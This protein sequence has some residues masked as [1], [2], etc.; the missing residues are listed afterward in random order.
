MKICKL[1]N[2]LKKI[3]ILIMCLITLIFAMPVKSNAG[4]IET[5]IDIVL[6]I[7]DW[8]MFGL[9][10]LLGDGET[11]SYIAVNYKGGDFNRGTNGHIYNF[12]I[13]P[14]E[15]FRAGMKEKVYVAGTQT[16]EV[17]ASDENRDENDNMVQSYYFAP[18]MDENNEQIKKDGKP[19]W[20]VFE[21]QGQSGGVALAARQAYND[22][23]YVYVCEANSDDYH[24][25]MD[26]CTQDEYKNCTIQRKDLRSMFPEQSKEYGVDDEKITY[27]TADNLIE[28]ERTIIP[29]LDANFFDRSTGE[30]NN[31][32]DILRPVISGIYNSLTGFAI[33]TMMVVLLYI[34]IRIIISSATTEQSKYKQL[35]I[36]WVI[37]LCL[38]FS[39]HFIMSFIMSINQLIVNTLGNTKVDNY[40]ISL[41]NLEGDDAIGLYTS[42]DKITKNRNPKVANFVA[43][44]LDY[45]DGFSKFQI[46]GNGMVNTKKFGQVHINARIYKVPGFINRSVL[47]KSEDEWADVVIYRCN[48]AEYLRSCITVDT[49]YVTYLKYKGNNVEAQYDGEAAY[50]DDQS[51]DD[52]NQDNENQDDDEKQYTATFWAYAAMYMLV[53]FQTIA[54]AVKYINRVIK[55][56]FL[57]MIAP[58]IAIMYPMD[59]VG[60][61]KAQ[62]FNMWFKEYLF[63]TLLQPLH[64][65]LYTI[66]IV[67]AEELAQNHCIYAIGFYAFMLFAEGFFKKMFGFD[68]ANVPKGLGSPMAYEFGRKIFDGITGLG[69]PGSLGNKGGGAD[70]ALGGKMKRAKA[71]FGNPMAN[72]SGNSVPGNSGMQND[73][74]SGNS[75]NLTNP[76]LG[77]G[78]HG[79]PASGGSENSSNTSN[80]SS[81]AP[82]ASGRV[83]NGLGNAMGLARHGIGGVKRD[84]VRK[85]TGGRTGSIKTALK[86]HKLDML[87]TAASGLGKGVAKTA[88]RAIGTAAGAALGLASGVFG[89]ALTGDSSY[90]TKGV[91][92]GAAAGFNRSKNTESRVARRL[93][94][95][96]KMLAAENVGYAAQL[97]KDEFLKNNYKYFDSLSDSKRQEVMET[98]D[99]FAPYMD[100]KDT[101]DLEAMND[102]YQQNKENMSL[103]DMYNARQDAKSWGDL[104]DSSKRK[105]YED[106]LVSEKRRELEEAANAGQI[107]VSCSDSE[108]EAEINRQKSVEAQEIKAKYDKD[109]RSTQESAFME[110]QLGNAT[111]A[112]ALKK[113]AEKLKAEKT[114]KIKELDDKNKRAQYENAAIEALR[115]QKIDAQIDYSDIHKKANMTAS[116]QKKT[117]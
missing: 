20:I 12:N 5:F 26:K 70:P 19:I 16:I 15:I 77:Q 39:M 109:I 49:D 53:A 102:L 52:G 108:I 113:E 11:K 59:K 96:K 69:P 44:K 31:S 7:P 35:L 116:Y 91:S 42:W 22:K 10:V 36:D 63:N 55:L 85:I 67:G 58:L 76:A 4:V 48:I 40:Y 37:G 111:E 34:G 73:S 64:L 47:L 51:Q 79:D 24:K 54:F 101:D 45:N 60:D 21:Y 17:R 38:V 23:H 80:S 95:S 117:K 30:K 83:M 99:T 46:D 71:K 8:A 105:D 110:Q 86:G 33:I 2:K 72:N 104:T 114:S 103:E 82:G 75:K 89:A 25:I 32:A 27:Y 94:D 13:T 84:F 66:F 115:Q 3:F 61:G 88:N 9:N 78:S 14:A 74:G 87:G 6:N 92:T 68:K 29:L 57:T 41:S 90:I 107:D 18:V 1:K 106:Y 65:L 97:S 93:E 100:F 112:E 28:E 50:K 81:T 62:T 43:E 56:A 98:L